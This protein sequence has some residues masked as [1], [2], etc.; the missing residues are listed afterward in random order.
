[1]I[2]SVAFLSTFNVIVDWLRLA[3]PFDITYVIGLKLGVQSWQ[4]D[5]FSQRILVAAFFKGIFQ[6][7]NSRDLRNVKYIFELDDVVFEFPLT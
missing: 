7:V 1:M 2:L 6:V 4:K 3:S 5:K